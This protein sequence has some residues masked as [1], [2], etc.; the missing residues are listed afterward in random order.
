MLNDVAYVSRTGYHNTI[1]EIDPLA[2]LVAQ[3]LV[4]TDW[5]ERYGLSYEDTLQL[6]YAEWIR[7]QN[8]LNSRSTVPS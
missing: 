1:C 4:T 2:K 7:M 6:T 3:Y 5:V 8:A